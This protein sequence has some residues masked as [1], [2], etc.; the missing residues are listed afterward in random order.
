[1]R[2]FEKQRMGWIAETLLVFG[3]INRRHLMKKFGVSEQQASKDLQT[4]QQAHP[5]VM[6]YNQSAKRYEASDA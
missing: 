4:F 5:G 6:I 2:W 3:F 1:M